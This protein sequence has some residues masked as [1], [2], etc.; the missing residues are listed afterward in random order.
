MQSRRTLSQSIRVVIENGWGYLRKPKTIALLWRYWQLVALMILFALDIAVILLGKLISMREFGVTLQRHGHP[1]CQ[2][3]VINGSLITAS[4]CT[5]GKEPFDVYS[6][7]GEKLET[8]TS[9]T[10]KYRTGFSKDFTLPDV[11]MTDRTL[12]TIG[13]CPFY[14]KITSGRYCHFSPD[15]TVLAS[16]D[17]ALPLGSSGTVV[18]NEWNNPCALYVGFYKINDHGHEQEIGIFKKLE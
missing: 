5:V 13:H 12:V 6:L 3:A 18:F 4:H 9:A 8:M 2:G 17:C 16:Y 14:G 1:F 10:L 15:K 11:A 7:D